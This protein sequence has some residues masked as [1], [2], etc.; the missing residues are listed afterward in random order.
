VTPPLAPDKGP[1][2]VRLYDA[3]KWNI[4]RKCPVC[5]STEEHTP[6]CGVGALLT[7]ARPLVEG[8]RSGELVTVEVTLAVYENEGDMDADVV[9]SKLG[10]D[11]RWC[12][13]APEGSQ[14]TR[15]TVYAKRPQ[16]ATIHSSVSES[17]RL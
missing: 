17:E 8:I 6:G 2:I 10:K 1:M 12:N 9:T 3:L 15:A 7:A 14:L 5:S 4:P 13:R 11:E 16:P